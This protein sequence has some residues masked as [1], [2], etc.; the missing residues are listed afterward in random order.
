MIYLLSDYSRSKRVDGSETPRSSLR[1]LYD[2]LRTEA[3]VLSLRDVRM[4]REPR[5]EV[6]ADVEGGDV[7]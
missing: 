1:G 7:A 3:E 2:Q 5:V 4:A 6:P